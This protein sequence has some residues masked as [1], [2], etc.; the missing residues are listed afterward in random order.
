MWWVVCVCDLVGRTLSLPQHADTVWSAL[1]LGSVGLDLPVWM[2]HAPLSWEFTFCSLCKLTC[3]S[4]NAPNLYS[5]FQQKQLL[6]MVLKWWWCHFWHARDETGIAVAGCQLPSSE[7]LSGNESTQLGREHREHLL[8]PLLEVTP[9]ND[10]LFKKTLHYFFDFVH[11]NNI[12]P[13]KYC[14]HHSIFF[15]IKVQETYDI[16][17]W[18][19]YKIFCIFSSFKTSKTSRKLKLFNMTPIKTD[20]CLYRPPPPEKVR[21]N[22]FIPNLHLHRPLEEK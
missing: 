17:F 19:T 4:Y 15:F 22:S 6:W 21:R 18:L 16:F 11:L 20:P 14:T 7:L 10:T 9:P 3:I 8:K 5:A 12:P 2:G 1:W 13:S